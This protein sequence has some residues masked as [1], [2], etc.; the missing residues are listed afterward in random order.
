MRP[1]RRRPDSGSPARRTRS[2]HHVVHAPP[3]RIRRAA[4]VVGPPRSCVPPLLQPGPA[5]GSQAALH[6]QGAGIEVGEAR[7]GQ[8]LDAERFDRERSG[9]G[10]AAGLAGAVFVGKPSAAPRPA[11]G[12]AG[13]QPATTPMSVLRTTLSA[14]SSL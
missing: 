2:G 8:R 4:P 7:A 5:R 11:A 10:A 13:R 14:N 6:G 12:T 9:G 3:T 1:G